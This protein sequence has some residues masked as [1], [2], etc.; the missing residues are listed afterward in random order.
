MKIGRIILRASIWIQQ[1]AFWVKESWAWSTAESPKW[2]FKKYHLVQIVLVMFGKTFQITYIECWMNTSPWRRISVRLPYET[3]YFKRTN[4]RSQMENNTKMIVLYRAIYYIV[5][6]NTSANSLY[7]G[8]A[9]SFIS[10]KIHIQSSPFP[11][12]FIPFLFQKRQLFPILLP[13]LWINSNL[14]E[15]NQSI[16]LNGIESQIDEIADFC[17]DLSINIYTNNKSYSQIIVIESD[18]NNT[19]RSKHSN[20][21]ELMYASFQMFIAKP[22]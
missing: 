13:K 4:R 2:K 16:R 20:I 7:L 1:P 14:P 10:S 22:D 15:I 8:T 18:N 3:I 19:S 17:S 12:P 9:Q 5:S 21:H 6:V 11:I